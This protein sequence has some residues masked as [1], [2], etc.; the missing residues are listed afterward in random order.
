M[1]DGFT[2]ARLRRHWPALVVAVGATLALARPGP[3]A[4]IDKQD[5]NQVQRGHYLAVAS[6]CAA[7]HTLPGS[8]H[9]F[10]GGRAIETPFGLLVSPNITPDP[11]T[12]IGAWTD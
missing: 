2:I 11:L 12:G 8:G 10:A 9:D 4:V 3:A 1:P 7:C 5:Y 6:D